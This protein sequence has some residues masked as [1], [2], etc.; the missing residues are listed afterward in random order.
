MEKYKKYLRP[1]FSGVIFYIL[2]MYTPVFGVISNLMYSIGFSGFFGHIL[3]EAATAF[4]LYLPLPFISKNKK[5]GLISAM[6]VIVLIHF[7]SLVA[8]S[9]SLTSLFAM[10]ASIAGVYAAHIFIHEVFGEKMDA[11]IQGSTKKDETLVESST[12]VTSCMNVP[13]LYKKVCTV[14]KVESSN[15]SHT[16]INSRTYYDT[17]YVGDDVINVPRLS[18]SSTH[19]KKIVQ[20]I[21]TQEEDGSE[22]KRTFINHDFDFREG[23][24]MEILATEQ[25]V[26]E[27]VHNKNTGSIF[28]LKNFVIQK[29]E[30][31][32]TNN[33]TD[34]LMACIGL[35][36][37]G[38]NVIGSV[39]GLNDAN[40]RYQ[41]DIKR[42]YIGNHLR[43]S[44][45]IFLL[46]SLLSTF[47]FF[48]SLF[49]DGQPIVD[50][51]LKGTMWYFIIASSMI[52]FLMVRALGQTKKNVDRMQ[53]I[54]SKKAISLFAKDS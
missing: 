6:L 8:S 15:E 28:H 38:V 51:T 50:I 49:G 3:T 13:D 42:D 52:G 53:E 33:I 26:I 36:V 9:F 16:E 40:K 10:A 34:F 14:M 31:D 17:K 45:V 23:H 5:N 24:V 12:S 21:W 27:Y 30:L 22:K 2:L 41:S 46:F 39:L 19:H 18:V 4:L 54:L 20:D 1:V 25:G 37:P 43:N 32:V 35:A 48:T 29:D 47:V 44:F 11:N 7:N